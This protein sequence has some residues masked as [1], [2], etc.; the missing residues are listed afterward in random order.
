MSGD[1]DALISQRTIRPLA[2]PELRLNSGRFVVAELAEDYALSLYLYDPAQC[3]AWAA[4]F[5]KAAG[6]LED[7]ER[8]AAE[9]TS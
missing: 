7:A 8:P 5:G 6:M 4:A 1:K 9:V 3:R 2:V